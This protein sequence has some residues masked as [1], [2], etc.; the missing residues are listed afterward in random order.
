[1]KSPGYERKP[2][3]TQ[4]AL[5]RLDLR[6][7]PTSMST[8]A[9]LA[10]GLKVEARQ[11]SHLQVSLES[12]RPGSRHER[13]LIQRIGA[14]QRLMSRQEVR[15]DRIVAQSGGTTG[16]GSPTGLPAN[17]SQTLDVI[18]SA[19][20]QNPGGFPANV[21]TTDGA[22]MVVI[23]GTSVGIQ[24]QDSNPAQFDTLLTDLQNAG[25]QVTLSSAQYGTVVGMLPI[26]QLPAVGQ[27]PEVTSVTPLFRPTLN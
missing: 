26:S 22:N 15:L 1:M 16:P 25:M 2:L 4:P 21:P 27:L 5:E 12:A 8:G 11:V 13:V 9:V 10:A 19:Y 14:E 20:E 24:V 18:Y 7:A 23:Q 6:I 3:K 17:V